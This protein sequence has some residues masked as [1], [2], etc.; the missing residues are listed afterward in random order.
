[1]TKGKREETGKFRCKFCKKLRNDSEYGMTH[2]GEPVC[3]YC[4]EAGW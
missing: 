4:V 2:L 3:T 1:M